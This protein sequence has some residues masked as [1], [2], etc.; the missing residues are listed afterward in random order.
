M[1]SNPYTE[2]ALVQRTT[3]EYLERE[4][5][6]ESVYAYNTEGFGPNSLLGRSSDRD[7]VLVPTLREQLE[8]L[9]PGLPDD[10]YDDAVRQLT[11]AAA[12]KTLVAANRD[13]Y[14]LIRDGVTVTFRDFKNSRIKRRLRVIDFE[15]PDNNR[16]LCV[17]ELWI[18]GD[19]YRRRADIIGFVNGLPLL[20]IEC[21]NI[22]T[23]LRAAYEKNY[24]DYRDTIPRLFHHNAIVMFAN[25]ERARIGSVTSEW[26]HF[27]EWKRLEEDE[28]GSV[29]ME[30]LLKGV[31]NRRTFLD[32]L[33][34]FIL[35]DDSSGE[36]R[37]ILARNHQ[38]LGVNPRGGGRPQQGDP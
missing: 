38:F 8:R 35:F 12:S 29:D 11:A 3:A 30:T 20:F 14:D 19:V 13:N 18:R 33:E 1:T 9:N 32:L 25:G 24:S 37:K 7:A 5:G 36:T 26:E 2:D 6:W 22:H 4:L 21:K 15:T 27:H 17:R 16:F 34:N 10:A 31:C 23:D 28:P